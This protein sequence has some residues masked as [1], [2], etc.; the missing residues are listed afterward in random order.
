MS[1]RVTRREDRGWPPS[2]RTEERALRRRKKRLNRPV[3]QQT[4]LFPGMETY[5]TWDR[6]LGKWGHS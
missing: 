3:L 5:E 4:A 1:K 2:R 6:R